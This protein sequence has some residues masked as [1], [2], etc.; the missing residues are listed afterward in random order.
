MNKQ[1][2]QHIAKA[3][4]TLREVESRGWHSILLS[5]VDA[6]NEAGEALKLI[7]IAACYKDFTREFA[8]ADIETKLEAYA[9]LRAAYDNRKFQSRKHLSKAQFERL[10]MMHLE[11]F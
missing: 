11:R 1:F 7:K 9:V 10:L 2:Q 8:D 6:I 4:K 5:S 3:Q